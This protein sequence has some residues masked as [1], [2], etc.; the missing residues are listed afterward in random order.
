MHGR[1]W[2]ILLIDDDREDYILTH[3]LLADIKY[4]SFDLDWLNTYEAGLKSIQDG[5]YDVYLID[6]RLGEQDGL[7]LVREA[8]AFGCSAPIILMTGQGSYDVDIE[9]MQAGATDYLVKGEF[10]G[11]LLERTIRYAVENKQARE[12]LR[13]AHNELEQR[14]EERTRALADANEKLRAENQERQKAEEALRKSETRFRTLAETTSSAI[15][16][17]EG[18]TIRYANPA[19]KM[20]TAMTQMS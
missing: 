17:L 9:A 11:P 13:K 6:Y 3:S 14:V 12:A 7:Q 5:A 2:K 15:F 8:V 18:I 1:L 4:G 16:I 19:V 20:I 10:S